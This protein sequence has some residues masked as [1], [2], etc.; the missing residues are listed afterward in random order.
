MGL[1][2]KPVYL[3]WNPFTEINRHPLD[4]CSWGFPSRLINNTIKSFDSLVD[5][6]REGVRVPTVAQWI[7]NPTAEAQVAAE[8]QVQSLA[9]RNGLKDLVL[10]QPRLRSQLWLGSSP[11]PRNLHMLWVQP[12]KKE[13]Y[14]VSRCEVWHVA[15]RATSLPAVQDCHL[16]THSLP[17]SSPVVKKP[18]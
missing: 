12:L 1:V 4:L 6:K 17:V 13:V 10:L 2:L 7:K 3:K 11:W 8:G 18:V 5:T 9:G 14:F 15:V 16:P